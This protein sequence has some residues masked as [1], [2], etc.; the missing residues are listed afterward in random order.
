MQTRPKL[1]VLT[2]EHLNLAIRLVD[3]LEQTAVGLLLGQ[4]LADHLLHVR[5]LRSRL[6][7]LKRIVNLLGILHFL[8]HT[9]AKVNVPQTLNLK[10]LA[11]V[12]L[13]RIFV[14]VG[15]SLSDFS[16]L[17]LTLN[18]ARHGGFFVLD[19]FLKLKNALLSVLLLELDVLHQAIKNSLGLQALL[20]CLALL[21]VLEFKDG[22][23]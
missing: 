3:C 14:F 19:A 4:K 2:P 9:L 8:Y 20:L 22:L 18:A 1:L 13:T 17:A 21:G 15:G 11:R 10:I 5:D 7:R 6:D 12:Q 23:L 16:V